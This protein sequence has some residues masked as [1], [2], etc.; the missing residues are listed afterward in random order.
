[1]QS[2]S[3]SSL[4]ERPASSQQAPTISVIPPAPSQ[5]ATPINQQV[6]ANTPVPGSS[7]V[8]TTGAVEAERPTIASFGTKSAKTKQKRKRL[9][10]ELLQADL[11]D[12]KNKSKDAVEAKILIPAASEVSAP[13]REGSSRAV[14]IDL[15]REPT[16]PE[17]TQTS[18]RL[19]DTSCQRHEESVNEDVTI[20]PEGSG[21]LPDAAQP[22]A[23]SG[24]LVAVVSSGSAV[25]NATHSAPI[26]STAAATANDGDTDLPPI[27]RIENDANTTP[28]RVSV[29][30]VHPAESST[31][32]EP[33]QAEDAFSDMEVDGSSDPQVEEHP[34]KRRKISPCMD[35]QVEQLL[36]S[37]TKDVD[38]RRAANGY[39]PLG[40]STR[41]SPYLQ[42]YP[43]PLE[44]P[45]RL[46]TPGEGWHF[47]LSRL[48]AAI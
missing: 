46:L 35:E 11:G 1:M 19:H 32:L 43:P 44:L 7:Q 23:G 14:A 27:S 18:P 15:L 45:A 6:V 48:G 42:Q 12:V 38:K 30:S 4:P 34:N 24:L 33:N 25:L 3:L 41:Q 40:G 37:I 21:G 13:L 17:Q 39:S 5:P 16:A 31:P 29:A 36:S 8:A 9:A 47:P 22:A 28:P 10:A 26:P 20:L 2:Q